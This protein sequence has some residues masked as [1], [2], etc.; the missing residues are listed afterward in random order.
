MVDIY[1]PW[2]DNQVII[3]DNYQ[4]SL[5]RLESLL[6][7]LQQDPKTLKEY[8]NII[9]EQI[10]RGVIERVDETSTTNA[11]R[12]HFLP[13]HAI[14]RRDKKTTKL[15][16][17]YDASAK[18]VG[19]SLND[20]LYSGP[21]LAENIVDILLRFRCHPTALFGDIEKAFLMIAIAKEDRDVLRFLWVDDITKNDPK[22][23]IYR[24]TRVVFGVMDSQ[25]LLNGTIKH[26]IEKYQEED[27]EFVQKFLSDIYVDDLSFGD[28][29]DNAAYELYIKSKQ[30]LSEG[31]FNLRKFLSNSPILMQII[32]QNEETPTIGLSTTDVVNDVCTEDKSYSKSTVGN[33]Q[34]VL[35][36]KEEKILGIRWNYVSDTFIFNFQRI[37]Q[38]A[39]ELE[40]TKA[41]CHWYQI[42]FLRPLGISRTHNS[43]IKDVLSGAMPI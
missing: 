27:P 19:H 18:S 42:P 25:F 20:C 17:V 23:M 22:I 40:P 5:R 2:K 9:Q 29:D 11:S 10:A 33:P 39:R 13:H 3:P 31:G 8:D 38:A 43:Q 14:I 41:K 26:H 7:R 28:K 34:E 21:S 12:V 37:V 30:R 1:L 24:F 36:E 32:Q 35:L 15:R 4:L 16:I 6:R